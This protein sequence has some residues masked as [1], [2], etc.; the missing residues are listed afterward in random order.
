MFHIKM[1]LFV[2]PASLIL[3]LSFLRIKYKT[4]HNS[5]FAVSNNVTLAIQK[6]PWLFYIFLNSTEKELE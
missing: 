2:F 4:F 1:D 3:L 5:I 6:L